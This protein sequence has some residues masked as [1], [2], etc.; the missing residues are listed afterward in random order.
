[1]Q[2]CS[3]RLRLRVAV[4]CS[5]LPASNRTLIVTI[6]T[7]LFDTMGD[8]LIISVPVVLLRRVRISLRQKFGVGIT[9]CL[10]LLMIVIALVRICG[11]YLAPHKVDILWIEF[12]NQ[13]QC[14]V[15]VTMF[16]MTAFRSFCVKAA[17]QAPNGQEGQQHR[18]SS[19]WE[20]DLQ[21]L[22]S[23]IGNRSSA[24]EHTDN[25][26]PVVQ[27]FICK[28]HTEV[29]LHQP[30]IPRATLTGIRTAIAATGD[31]ETQAGAEIT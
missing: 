18:F 26:V 11:M 12:W 4:H 8:I 30:E 27:Q 31:L 16:S 21:K 17:P 15:A 2:N 1:M 19:L 24:R 20:S 13:Q 23:L 22:K 10:S 29:A 9:L 7:T 6:I 28:Q 14:N 5:S 25:C 3:S